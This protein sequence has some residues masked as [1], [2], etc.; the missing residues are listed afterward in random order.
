MFHVYDSTTDE[1]FPK[2]AIAAVSYDPLW[3]LIRAQCN[4]ATLDKARASVATLDA[5]VSQTSDAEEKRRRVWRASNLLRAVPLALPS[6][7]GIPHNRDV[8]RFLPTQTGRYY[9][10]S[11]EVGLPTYWDWAITRRG[12]LLMWQR[13]P[14]LFR[15]IVKYKQ[16]LAR[17]PCHQGP[18]LELHYYLAICQEIMDEYMPIGALYEET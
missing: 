9:K 18:K 6:A 2:H 4:F 5:Y 11:Q 17:R 8:G 1:E 12:A 10:L 15:R 3:Q 7:L 13:L 16:G 14:G